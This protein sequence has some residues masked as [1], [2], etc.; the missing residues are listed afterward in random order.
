M[1]TKWK[2]F[3]FYMLKQLM[4]QFC[5]G[6]Q[7]ICMSLLLYSHNLLQLV[8]VLRVAFIHQQGEH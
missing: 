3:Y 2:L 6:V 5:N 7:T 1:L 8:T 4:Q